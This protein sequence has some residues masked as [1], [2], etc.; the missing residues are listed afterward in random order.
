[1]E[2][3][4]PSWLRKVTDAAGKEITPGA[5]VT[6]TASGLAGTV[7]C[8]DGRNGEVW[9]RLTH[10]ASALN[11]RK[12]KDVRVAEVGTEKPLTCFAATDEDG[13]THLF[14]TYPKRESC[15]FGGYWDAGEQERMSLPP[16]LFP[17]L[18]WMDEPMAVDMMLA[19]AKR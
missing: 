3:K 2:T 10:T 4:L 6:D 5:I 15:T 19:P 9:V 8:V 11:C 16:E 14:N 13:T 1:M 7:E 18:R 12:I 17:D